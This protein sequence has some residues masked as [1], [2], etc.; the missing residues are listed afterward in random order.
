MQGSSNVT[1]L[2]CKLCCTIHKYNTW[3]HSYVKQWSHP[4]KPWY[5]GCIKRLDDPLY[6][7]HCH[8]SSCLPTCHFHWKAVD[9]LPLSVGWHYNPNT[10][11]PGKVEVDVQVTTAYNLHTHK[12]PRVTGD[13][14]RGQWQD[15]KVIKSDT[16]TGVMTRWFTWKC[17][18][19]C[20]TMTHTHAH[21]AT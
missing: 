12:R 21:G 4:T 3:V 14:S 9:P 16:T 13:T 2:F 1:F 7:P 19:H 10:T 5:N 15:G 18:S 8:F 17:S 11:G 6:L 20:H